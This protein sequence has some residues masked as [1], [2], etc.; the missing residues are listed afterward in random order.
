MAWRSAMRTNALLA[1]AMLL[2]GATGPSARGAEDGKEIFTTEAT[3]PCGVCHTLDDA[4]A[5]GEVGPNLDELKPTEERVRRA[6]KL[7][8][9]NMPPYDETLSE[10][11]IAAVS[12]YVAKAAQ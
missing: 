8:V 5:S 4:G 3:P 2:L 12:R 11:E 7:G 10:A 9:G 6:V 1:M